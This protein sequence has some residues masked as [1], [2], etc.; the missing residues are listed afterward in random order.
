MFLNVILC[1]CE[2]VISANINLIFIF[3]KSIFAYLSLRI[4]SLSLDGKAM[5]CLIG[6]FRTWFRK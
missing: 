3:K 4:Y 1:K 6:V 5:G 2:M